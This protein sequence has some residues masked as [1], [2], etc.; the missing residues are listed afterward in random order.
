MDA[1]MSWI[2]WTVILVAWPLIG[3]GVAYLVRPVRSRRGGL[4]G[5]ADGLAPP[6]VSYMRRVKRK[7]SLRAAAHHKT[8]REGTSGRRV[9]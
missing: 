1:P 9:H 4:A 3:L 2:T 5:D 6:V 8:R 7:S